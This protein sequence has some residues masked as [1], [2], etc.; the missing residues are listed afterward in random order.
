MKINT[1]AITLLYQNV[2]KR[3]R[4]RTSMA[5]N[6]LDVFLQIEIIAFE[7]SETME[8]NAVLFQE[9]VCCF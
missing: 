4:L 3:V 9:V 7:Y 2:L 8:T 5:Q 6:L 1:T